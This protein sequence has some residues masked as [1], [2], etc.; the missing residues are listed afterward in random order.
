MGRILLA[1]AFVF[2]SLAFAAPHA[3]MYDVNFDL[4]LN[5]KKVASP[6]MTMMEG[7]KS[8][9]SQESEDTTTFVE[10]T[11]TEGTLNGNKGILLKLV[12]GHMSE[13]GE[14]EILSNAQV[15]VNNGEPTQ[16]FVGDEGD[17]EKLSVAITAKRKAI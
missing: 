14:R 13:D 12:I 6:R 2:A 17:K 1:L 4:S 7:E 8:M 11:A 3:K 5:G 10:A 16:V 15:L 9:V